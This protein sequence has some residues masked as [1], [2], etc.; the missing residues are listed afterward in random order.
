[1]DL[2]K[3]FDLVALEKRIESLAKHN[4]ELA[5]SI[6][7]DFKVKSG[8][9]ALADVKIEELEKAINAE[10]RK[11]EI[12]DDRLLNL[13]VDPFI[14][15]LKLSIGTCGNFELSDCCVSM[16]DDFATTFDEYRPYLKP[17]FYSSLMELE[18][19]LN[20]IL[21][22]MK[23]TLQTAIEL[24]PADVL[25]ACAQLVGVFIT[26]SHVR[27]AFRTLPTKALTTEM[28][29]REGKALMQLA[30]ALKANRMI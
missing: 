5:E 13:R 29:S 21:Y 12:V 24:F 28:V 30:Q 17:F 19:R 23:L 3:D 18:M 11:E 10:L 6:D 25:L 16:P 1:M 4:K 26:R 27:N 7:V 15:F 14:N 2:E 22:P 8:E 20:Q 9:Q